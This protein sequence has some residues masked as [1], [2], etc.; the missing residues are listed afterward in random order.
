MCLFIESYEVNN[1]TVMIRLQKDTYGRD[2]NL[3]S[4]IPQEWHCG[5]FKP[6][7]QGL[8]QDL[9]AKNEH[10]VHNKVAY[11]WQHESVDIGSVND[12]YIQHV[13]YSRQCPNGDGSSSLFC[14]VNN[15]FASITKQQTKRLTPSVSPP[16]CDEH[17]LTLSLP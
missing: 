7:E 6:S 15:C 10:N 1:E 8:T 11:I 9:K 16:S 3:E 14:T 2:F 12:H 17:T 5:L 13:I 4:G